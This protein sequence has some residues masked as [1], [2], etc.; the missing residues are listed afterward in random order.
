MG[1]VI[2]LPNIT[3]ESIVVTNDSSSNYTRPN[4]FNEKNYLNVRL[5]E[6]NGEKQ[7][8]LTIRLLPMDLET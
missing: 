5:D 8:T 1:N 2:N 4:A 3:P 7:K 6:K